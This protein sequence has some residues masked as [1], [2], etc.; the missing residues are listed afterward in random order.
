MYEPLLD[1]AAE[2]LD[3]PQ[4]EPRRVFHGR[5][6]MFE[7]LEHINLDWYPPVLLLTGYADVVDLE[8]LVDHIR[9]RDKHRQVISIVHQARSSRGAPAQ[10]IWGEDI[11]YTEVTENGIHYEVR[12]GV[13]QNAGLFLDMRPLRGWLKDYSQ[14]KNVLNLFSY[15]CSLSVAA[16]AGGARQVVSADMSKPSIEWGKRNHQLNEHDLRQ[17]RSLPHN[18]LK[19]WARIQKLGPF[20]TIIIDP[21]TRQKGSFNA[22]KHYAGIMKKL[23]NLASPGADIIASLNSPYLGSDYLPNLM[24]RYQGKIR[25][26]GEFPVSPEFVDRYPERA[27]KLFHFRNSG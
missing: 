20:D 7:G 21:P 14:G 11:R 2:F 9:V 25:L 15:T 6:H 13:N 18:I 22:E 27:L 5:G 26:I 1:R 24:T 8:Q 4:L 16:L 12:P 10:T 3:S 19:S 23:H 17:V